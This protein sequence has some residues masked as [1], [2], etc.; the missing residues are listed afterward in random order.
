MVAEVRSG[1]SLRSV[2][3][4]HGVPL[5][6]VQLWVA[7]AG[8][9][10]LDEVDWTDRSSARHRPPRIPA[11]LEDLI[12]D[13]RHDLRVTSDL[14]EFGAVA[15]HRALGER[16]VPWPVPS[17]RTIGRALERRGALDGVR[18]VRRTPPHPGWYLPDL[19]ARRVELDSFDI[20]D[21]LYLR[22]MPE[23]GILTVTSLH[24]GLV[25][26]WPDHGMRVG[27]ILPAIT[28][29]WRRFGLPAYAQFDNDSR[30]L[31]GMRNAD[32]LGTVIRACLALGVVPVF[33]PARETGFQAAVESLNWRWQAKVWAR[34]TDPD[35]A[36]LRR[37]SDRWVAAVRAR[38]APRIEA[39]PPR[40]PFPDEVVPWRM[41][42]GRI[43]FL[44]RTGDSGG[45]TLLGHRFHV[46]H[47]WPF[48]LVRAE[49]DLVEG[50]VDV[51]A[52]RRREPHD[53]PLLARIDYPVPDRWR[54]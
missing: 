41:P 21:G 14:G 48:R 36:S 52:L 11:A 50:R 40:R 18:R 19:A 2:A 20:V 54:T 26:A 30:F 15:I 24:G 27:Q 12:L 44:R 35:I 32:T 8:D 38:H 23:L 5:S 6:T 39:A 43:V 22:G 45:I 1:A 51:F 47:H 13:L 9:L 7:R 46:D 25:G 34:T 29:H 33:T 10:P 49:V 17:V 16:P 37:R 3:R 31:G 42:G 28:G 53:Q 4:R